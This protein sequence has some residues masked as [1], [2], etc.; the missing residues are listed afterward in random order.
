[1]WLGGLSG[2]WVICGGLNFGG[3]LVSTDRCFCPRCRTFDFWSMT[4]EGIACG[5]SL[6]ANFGWVM[7]HF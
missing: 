7:V 2:V 5:S 4:F 6:K 3:S 1:M